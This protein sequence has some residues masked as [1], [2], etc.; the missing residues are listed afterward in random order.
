MRPAAGVALKSRLVGLEPPI[1]THVEIIELFRIC[2]RSPMRSPS[3]RH[4]C[5]QRKECPTEITTFKDMYVA[6]LQELVSVED[7]LADALLTMSEMA[8]HPRAQ[9]R[10]DGSSREHPCPARND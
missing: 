7:H 5:L 4:M 8:S 2:G 10:P 3:S 9:E 6:D 1:A